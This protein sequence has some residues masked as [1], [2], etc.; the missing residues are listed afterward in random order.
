[1]E[2]V[3]V[4]MVQAGIT[5]QQATVALQAI[6]HFFR[7]HPAERLSKITEVIFNGKDERSK[8]LN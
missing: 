4:M 8:F 2:V 3:D 6:I 7:T 1:M 5:R